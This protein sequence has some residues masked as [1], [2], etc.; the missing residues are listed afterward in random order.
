MKSR[1]CRR[2]ARSSLVGSAQWLSEDTGGRT[3]RVVVHDQWQRCSGT[4]SR[5]RRADANPRPLAARSGRLFQRHTDVGS[6]RFD[7][8]IESSHRFFR[9][10]GLHRHGRYKYEHH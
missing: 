9:H 2:I 3:G 10:S 7:L 5:K 6:E 4:D 1:V 8:Y